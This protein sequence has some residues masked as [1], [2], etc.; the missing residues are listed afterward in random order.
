M[1]ALGSLTAADLPVIVAVTIAA[2]QHRVD[3]I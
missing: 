3:W 1:L 2:G